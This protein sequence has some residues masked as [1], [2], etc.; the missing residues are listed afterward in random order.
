MRPTRGPMTRSSNNPL[1]KFREDSE[2]G[3]NIQLRDWIYVLEDIGFDGRALQMAYD[4][5][6]TSD[7][8]DKVAKE[9]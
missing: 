8:G 2:R 9:A 4:K 6:D 1:G 7:F 3:K 5:L